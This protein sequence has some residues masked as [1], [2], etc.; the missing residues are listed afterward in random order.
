MW[1]L[2]SISLRISTIEERIKGS[3]AKIDRLND[4]SDLLDTLKDSLQE[5]VGDTLEN[6]QP[7]S[8]FDHIAGAAMQMIQ[9]KMAASMNALPAGIGERL[10]DI[11]EENL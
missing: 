10:N 5:I 11:V 4:P 1:F 7:P 9:M 6:M 2:S 8:A 3:S